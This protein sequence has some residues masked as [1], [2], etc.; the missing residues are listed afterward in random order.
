MASSSAAKVAALQ[1]MAA[2]G[3]ML[4][5][6][7]MYPPGHA[8]VE[9]GL[10]QLTSQFRRYFEVQVTL[11][12]GIA[13]DRVYLDDEELSKDEFILA[14]GQSLHQ[15][16]VA[17]L[18]F[19]RGL[20]RAEL[21][22]FFETLAVDPLSARRAGGYKRILASRGV[23][24]IEVIEIEYQLKE[25]EIE[26]QLSALS[27]AEVW[28][29]I[30][31]GWRAGADPTWSDLLFAQRLLGSAG[32]LGAIL[33][34]VVGVNTRTDEASRAADAFLHMIATL[35]PDHSK[36]GAAAVSEF[37]GQVQRVVEMVNPN[38]LHALM[39]QTVSQKAVGRRTEAVDTVLRRLDDRR[40]TRGLLEGLDPKPAK[41]QEFGRTYL[42]F[43]TPDREAG[44]LAETADVLRDHDNRQNRVYVDLAAAMEKAGTSAPALQRLSAAL[45]KSLADEAMGEAPIRRFLEANHAANPNLRDFLSDARIEEDHAYTLLN[46][47]ELVHK[48]ES[49]AFYAEGLDDLIAG[50]I[51]TGR[52]ELAATMVKT[53]RRHAS[54]ANDCPPARQ[55]ARKLLVALRREELAEEIL[56]ALSQWAKEQSGVLTD[57]LT[58]LDTAAHAPLLRALERETSRSSRALILQALEH[59]GGAV[60][61]MVR[62]RL[63]HEEWFVVRNAVELLARLDPGDVVECFAEAAGHAEPRVRK[64]VARVVE[65]KHGEAGA[66]VL[67]KLAED[68][69]E[70]VRHQAILNLGRFRGS[71]AAATALSESLRRK[72]PFAGDLKAEEMALKALGAIRVP[73]A[74]DVMTAYLSRAGLFGGPDR[75]L[76]CAAAKSIAG[77]GDPH[78]LEALRK[79]AKSWNRALSQVCKECLEQA[80]TL[81]TS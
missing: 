32:R 11:G 52:Y 4:R 12:V 66:Q 42:Y 8:I 45:N 48:S 73:A 18:V 75:A 79:G 65:S 21:S 34:M 76:L 53:L 46:A 22:S 19:H 23:A 81:E 5:K 77:L 60:C 13:N 29:R 38:S 27:D 25:D 44:V 59:A 47:L 2:F 9:Q 61:G 20:T 62:E 36:A 56:Q 31:R 40:L 71:P 67:G 80:R 6:Y 14:L 68:S 15:H 39:E 63:K 58:A 1:V 10:D 43:V 26:Q 50:F 17:G 33:D 16:G 69:D 55:V 28:R 7:N 30:A 24:Y 41:L 70:G 54:L 74:L 37:H 35:T 72:P 78:G 3:S 64:T 51:H 49:Y 57:L